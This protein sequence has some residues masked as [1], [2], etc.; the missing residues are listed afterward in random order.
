MTT[1][2]TSQAALSDSDAWKSLASHQRDLVGF[3]LRSAFADDPHRAGSMTLTAGD[4]TV[5]FS[6][7][8]A[9]E[10]TIARLVALAEHTGL[11][12]HRD[13]MFGGDAINGT[14]GRSVLHTALRSAGPVLVDGC[15]VVPGIRR[16]L[17][18]MAAAADRIRS[19]DWLGATGRPITTVVNIGIGG[20]DL[21]PLMVTTALRHLVPL[22]LSV[23]FV[24]NIDGAH[25][26]AVLADLDPE[27]TL[28]I[29]ASKTF[30]TIET[31]TNARSARA[32]LLDG[33]ASATGTSRNNSGNGNSNAVARHFVALSTN[34]DGVA[35]FGIDTSNMFEFW[36]WVGGRY[37]VGSAVGFSVMC[38]IGSA[39]FERFLE[40]FRL[41]DDHFYNAP[42]AQNGPVLAGLLGIWYR[43][44]WGWESHAVLP[45]AQ[46]LDRFPA[47]LQ[48]LDMESNGKRVTRGGSVVGWDTGP[49]VWGEPGTNGQHAFYQLLH[50]G[51]SPVP[52]DFIGF[53]E[54][55]PAHVASIDTG[56][57]HRLLFANLVAQSEALALGRT[58]DE[59][60]AAGVA[61]ELVAHKTFPGNRPSTVITAPAL[62]PSVVGQLIAFYEHRVF[63][64]GSV[65]GLNS[66][67]Q[68]G[69]ELG[70]VL[71]SRIG[72]ELEHGP[73]DGPEHD[74][75]TAALI[76]RFRAHNSSSGR[77]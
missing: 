63:T 2:P 46:A 71:A 5:D 57:H 14:E 49:I 22:D 44:F 11:A 19:G 58:A 54:P 53:L 64:Q 52:C 27:T 18:R 9:S 34:S 77:S 37:S 48:Q 75:S 39:N 30:T 61:D 23:R 8:L 62:T 38:A 42:L 76:A 20:S 31:M 26:D 25:L 73:D 69:V 55:E 32:W 45:Y 60:R 1:P 7:H 35:S 12:Q 15:D 29:V 70:K 10:E 56:T 4:L 41:I 66:F 21:G 59:V 40:G 28:F 33:L 16:V 13:A 65:W 24:S 72:T 17:E 68:W 67:D 36:D 51:T 43:N 74:S 3:D 6:K 50:Q 47:Y